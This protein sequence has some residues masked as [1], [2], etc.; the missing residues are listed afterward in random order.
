[1]LHVIL[2]YICLY[3]LTHGLAPATILTAPTSSHLFPGFHTVKVH[4]RLTNPA[5]PYL[6]VD[7]IVQHVMD[8]R[9]DVSVFSSGRCHAETMISI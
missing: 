2:V 9:P 3:C 5:L 6:G 1:M 8:P 4:A 7:G